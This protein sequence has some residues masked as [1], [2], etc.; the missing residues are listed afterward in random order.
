MYLHRGVKINPLP[1]SHPVIHAA[2]IDG[3]RSIDD[4]SSELYWG[5][6]PVA[7]KKPQQREK[8]KDD[9]KGIPGQLS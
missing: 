8:V 2:L 5:K 7:H 9:D 1:L 6:A 4:F 3:H